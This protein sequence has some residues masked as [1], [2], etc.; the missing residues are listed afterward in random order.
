M[1]LIWQRLEG[2]SG[3]DA[4]RALL[5]N[6]CG[7][8]LPQIATTAQGKPYFVDSPLHFSISHTK[9]HAFFCVS[10]KNVGIDAEPTHRRID[11][12]LISRYL[13]PAE[14]A[15]CT[16]AKDPGDALLRLWV[17]KE[18]EAKRTGRGWGN[19]LQNTDFDPEDPRIQIID[20]C[21]VAILEDE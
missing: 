15:R 9:N 21:Y 2:R 17:L 5:A 19:Y 3:H 14:Q 10:G 11:P 12:R 13:S 4:G 20:G 7:E 18:A 6:L 16:A 1:Q 8:P